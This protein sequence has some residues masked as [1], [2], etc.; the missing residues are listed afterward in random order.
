M[1]NGIQ[2]HE[3]TCKRGLKHGDPLSPLIFVIVANDLHHVTSEYREK[4]FIKGLG[5]RDNT[6]SVI[7]LHYLDNTLIFG[8]E[9][10]PE[11]MILRWVLLCYDK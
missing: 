11:A 2:G 4:G 9:S 6:N 3:I 7:N 10:L 8:Q 5:C 1:F